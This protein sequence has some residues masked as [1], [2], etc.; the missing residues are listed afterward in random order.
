M[1]KKWLL[2]AAASLLLAA[3]GKGESAEEAKETAAT[4]DKTEEH[5]SEEKA[6]KVEKETEEENSKEESSK[7]ELSQEEMDKLR[8]PTVPINS[9]YH[10]KDHTEQELVENYMDETG[11]IYFSLTEE[12]IRTIVSG[13]TSPK[14]SN[15]TNYSDAFIN[16]VDKQA[17]Q[18]QSQAEIDQIYKLI[19]ANQPKQLQGTDPSEYRTWEQAT[20]LERG[21]MQM[22]Y[23]V[24]PTMNDIKTAMDRDLYNHPAFVVGQEELEKL[25]APLVFAPAPQTPLD[26]KLFQNMK[27][28][29]AMW[30]EVGKFENPAE[31]KEEFEKVYAQVR[32]ETNNLFVRINYALTEDGF[33][34]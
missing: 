22:L 18:L 15:I 26:Y 6:E 20:N 4:A 19:L 25:G 34:E 11:R 33:G 8:I 16:P 5:A 28:V 21:M 24:G 32:Q 17:Y 14:V 13:T 30:G 2:V 3:C 10:E 1:M 9:P 29:Q 12:P 27:M 31:N 23:L 7:V